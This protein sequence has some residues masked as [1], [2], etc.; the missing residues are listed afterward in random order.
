[1]MLKFN[2][3]IL[4]TLAS[5]LMLALVSCNS[6]ED[7]SEIITP[8]TSGETG[9]SGDTG[10]T[11]GTGPIRPSNPDG[12]EYYRPKT[13]A[14]NDTCN[15]VY[16]YMPA[17]GQFINELKTG[18]F[19]GTQTTL[20][21]A[22]DYAMARLKKNLFVSL[23]AFGGYIVVGFDHSID[24]TGTPCALDCKYEWRYAEKAH[25]LLGGD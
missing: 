7:F 18:G 3:S 9:G 4:F 19:N 16:E 17:P 13:S 24:N 1:M 12:V 23:G 14:S 15:V 8:P 20:P 11:G 2:K 25:K 21:T 10:G 6:D 22:N 5:A